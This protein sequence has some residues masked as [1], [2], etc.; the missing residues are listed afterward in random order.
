MAD[1]FTALTKQAK[2][3]EARAA[4]IIMNNIYS[5]PP[6]YLLSLNSFVLIAAKVGLVFLTERQR[7]PVFLVFP[8][9][10]L[11]HTP[12]QRNNGKRHKYLQSSLK[13]RRADCERCE[14]PPG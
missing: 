4:N 5:E 7:R 1:N 9:N 3:R 13:S 14:P 10:L 8:Y 12:S 11:K 2:R 6:R